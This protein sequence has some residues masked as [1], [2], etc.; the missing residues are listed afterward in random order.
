MLRLIYYLIKNIDIV[1]C[2]YFL[3]VDCKYMNY[4]IWCRCFNLNW[5]FFFLE[6]GIK[7]MKMVWFKGKIK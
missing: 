3:F 5:F 1:L 4:I 2:I 6:N 7:G